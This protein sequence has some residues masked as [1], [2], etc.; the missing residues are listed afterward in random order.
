MKAIDPTGLI[1]HPGAT[2]SV[3]DPQALLADVRR[4]VPGVGVPAGQ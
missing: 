4:L 1:T 2:V 3:A